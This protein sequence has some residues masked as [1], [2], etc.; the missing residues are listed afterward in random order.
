MA[1]AGWAQPQRCSS[2]WTHRP[3]ASF[4]PPLPPLTTVYSHDARPPPSR[5]PPLPL[6]AC[7]R[8]S[9]APP[10][11]RH[12]RPPP[13]RADAFPTPPPD[14]T[15]A[16]DHRAAARER[17]D[18]LHAHAMAAHA[19]GGPA[20]AAEAAAALRHTL[21]LV[22]EALGDFDPLTLSVLSNLGAMLLAA[23]RADEAEPRCGEA[24]L[25][26]AAALG[27]DHPSTL[28]SRA[29]LA[30]VYR[31]QGRRGEAAAQ[32]RRVL[33]CRRAVLGAAHEESLAA[34]GNLA[35][36]LLEADERG[37]A[38]TPCVDAGEWE[39][40]GGD[41]ARGLEEAVALLA[42][43][44]RVRVAA[45]GAGCLHSLPQLTRALLSKMHAALMKQ[46]NLGNDVPGYDDLMQLVQLAMPSPSQA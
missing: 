28:A 13:P 5:S 30:T 46:P 25:R 33:S 11:W 17:L 21:S 38:R 34:M 18:A 16:A 29:N 41:A 27:D 14:A 31:T 42:E 1:L 6:Y 10:L 22:R 26:R 20:A 9:R 8:S 23:G 24:M 4:R 32:W 19:R 37:E 3:D 36:V 2:R 39:P 12:A 45:C 40:A 43:E 44:L 35:A 15:P 7:G